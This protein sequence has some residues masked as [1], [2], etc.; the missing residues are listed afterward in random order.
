LIFQ[1]EILRHPASSSS[2]SLHTDKK[3]RD[4]GGRMEGVVCLGAIYKNI[5]RSMQVRVQKEKGSGWQV[6]VA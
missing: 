6:R 2:S 1:G 3:K 5:Y 4:G